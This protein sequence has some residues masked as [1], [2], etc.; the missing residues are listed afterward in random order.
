MQDQQLGQIQL[1]DTRWWVQDEFVLRSAGFPAATVMKLSDAELAEA[2]TGDLSP[3]EFA[4]HYEQAAGRLAV[5]MRELSSD[6]LLREAVTWQNTSILTYCLKK[7]AN[8]RKLPTKER[9]RN[10]ITLASYLQR[11]A[12][13]NDT[14]GF[15]G[16]VTWARATR[17]PVGLSARPGAKLLSQRSVYFEWWAID[18]LARQLSEDPDVLPWLCPRVREEWTLTEDAARGVLGQ[19]VVLGPEERALLGLCNGTR[20][21]REI[22]GDGPGIN[23]LSALTD[24]G[25]LA[26]DL[27]GPFETHPEQTLRAKLMRIGDEA[28]RNRMLAPLDELVTARDQVSRAAGDQE[29]LAVALARLNET[30]EQITGVE[31]ARRKGEMY[32]GRTLV[33]EDASR[34]VEVELGTGFLD[35]I[36]TPL[37]LV[38][39]SADWLVSGVAEAYRERFLQLHQRI[40]QRLGT[41]DVPLARLVGA[42]TPD[43]MFN[44]RDLPPLIAEISAELC[45]RWETVLRI[46]DDV[47]HHQVSSADI[48]HVVREQF[49]RSPLPWSDA[50]HHSPDLMIA[51]RDAEAVSRGEFA[52]V[53]GEVHVAINTL[54]ARSLVQQHPDPSRL[55]A[56]AEAEHGRQRLLPVPSRFSSQ[57]NSRTYPKVLLSPEF[58]YWSMYSDTTGAPGPIISAA[59]L[60]VQHGDRGLIVRNW[61]TGAE[62]DLLELLGDMLSGA[63]TSSLSMVGTRSHRPRISIDQ[64]VVAR[65]AWTLSIDELNWPSITREADRFQ[66]AWRWRAEIGLPTRVF[67]K[68]FEEDKPYFL[69][70]TSPALVS[71]AAA[72]LRKCAGRP[73]SRMTFSEML[74]D[75]DQCWLT[76]AQGRRYTSELRLVFSDPAR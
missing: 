22:T 47:R 49:P 30:F 33:Y 52:A 23:V 67:F 65:E 64:L 68:S 17:E 28:L 21:I 4:A 2:A 70:F 59:E 66:A 54:D 19:T 40:S 6:P 61:R 32:A 15:F 24:R 25:I 10:A 56:R 51:A 58:T 63:V 76:D 38:L 12:V 74:P 50:R 35:R 41:D 31:S 9:R 16:P 71:L 8:D 11:Y 57:V 36:A 26:V 72:A 48:E 20:T 5:A 42:A 13:K 75:L 18:T 60:V 3:E 73:G 7:I 1:G 34:D 27:T 39:D 62:Y 29:R 44:R 14:I 37:A 45:R 43:L 55:I 46:P 53:L 69:D